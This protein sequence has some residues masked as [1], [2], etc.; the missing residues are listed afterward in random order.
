[1]LL[2]LQPCSRCVS[3]AE[4]VFLAPVLKECNLQSCMCCTRPGWHLDFNMCPAG[5]LTTYGSDLST[6]SPAEPTP[7]VSEATVHMSH[8]A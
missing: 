7:A 5:W 8:E 3:L 6:C 1:M 4:H 2:H